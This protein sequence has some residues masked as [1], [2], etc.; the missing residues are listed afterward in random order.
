MNTIRLINLGL[1]ALVFTATTGMAQDLIPPPPQDQGLPYTRSAQLV[2]MELI[3]DYTAVF[4]GSRYAYVKGH[5]VRLDETNW[6]FEAER[7]TDG[8]VYVP[9]AF[10]RA[11]LKKD[12]TFDPAPEYLKR[13]SLASHRS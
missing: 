5:K 11:A 4:V 13:K 10:V 8:D 6:R 1:I 12:I 7:R 9:E 2:S 3:K